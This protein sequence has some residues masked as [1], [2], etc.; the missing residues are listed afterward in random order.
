MN[1]VFAAL[2]ADDLARVRRLEI[3]D[4]IEEWQLIS[5]H[6]CISTAFK[7]GSGIGL[8]HMPF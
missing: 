8:D 7:D 6:Y 5:G 2:P 3:F 1:A 4:E